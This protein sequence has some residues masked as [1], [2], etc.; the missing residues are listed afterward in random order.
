MNIGRTVR[1]L[2]LATVAGLAAF[3]FVGFAAAD[4]EAAG[5]RRVAVSFGYGPRHVGYGYGYHGP[6]YHPP[7]V[8]YHKVYHPEY[9]HWTPWRGWHT[10]GHYD[11][12]PH[13]TPGHFDYHHGDHID[14]NPHFHD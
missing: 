14:L 7:S 6:I 11:R 9:S 2:G 1:K 5:G 13:Y 12:V 8:H 4:A 10:H 3:T